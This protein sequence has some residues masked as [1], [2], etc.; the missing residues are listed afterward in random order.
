LTQLVIVIGKTLDGKYYFRIRIDGGR[1]LLTSR[2]FMRIE[3]CMNEIYGIQQYSTFEMVQDYNR[4][5]GHRYTLIGAW[6]KMVGEST[7]Y[8]Y[9]YD[10]KYDMDLLK[11]LLCK[12]EVIDNSALIRF[13]RPVRI[14]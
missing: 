10:M 4:D 7:F 5:N 8:T 6:G 3:K 13:F 14:K 1:I 12:A 2:E 11:K 9:L